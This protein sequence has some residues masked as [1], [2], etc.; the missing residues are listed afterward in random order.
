MLESEIAEINRRLNP[1]YAINE[2]TFYNMFE[3]EIYS[4]SLLYEPAL[5][6]KLYKS[7]EDLNEFKRENNLI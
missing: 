7:L 3:D 2:L 6:K 4:I 1:Y 5:G